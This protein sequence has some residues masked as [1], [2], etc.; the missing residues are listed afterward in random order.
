MLLVPGG[1]Y[2]AI[3][4]APACFPRNWA[5]SRVL[6]PRPESA[7]T[8]MWC[9]RQRVSSEGVSRSLVVAIK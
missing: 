1:R 2:G 6:I 4:A 3:T 7:N 9:R 5:W 8:A